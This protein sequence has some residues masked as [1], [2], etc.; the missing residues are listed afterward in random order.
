MF[1]A[2]CYLCEF[3]VFLLMTC[4]LGL[5]SSGGFLH[6]K[7]KLSELV[8]PDSNH[9]VV[10]HGIVWSPTEQNTVAQ[11]TLHPPHT[12]NFFPKCFYWKPSEQGH[13]EK[14]EV[15]VGPHITIVMPKHCL[16][17]KENITFD[18][19]LALSQ[20]P[21]PFPLLCRKKVP[22]C[23]HHG[24][25]ASP[26]LWPLLHPLDSLLRE[27]KVK[28]SVQQKFEQHLINIKNVFEKAFICSILLWQERSHGSKPRS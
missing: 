14:S 6:K 28:L 9:L 19:Q 12:H 24:S 21:T 20:L 1:K 16:T 17:A 10:S 25:P 26:H 4:C 22:P 11:L 15:T 2:C 13:H 8:L 23:L 7:P 3:L 27:D 18:S 5:Q